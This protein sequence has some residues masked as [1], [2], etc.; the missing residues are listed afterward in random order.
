ME[1]LNL[2]HGGGKQTLNMLSASPKKKR[3]AEEISAK[4]VFLILQGENNPG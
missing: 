3:R 2:H 4:D 1:H